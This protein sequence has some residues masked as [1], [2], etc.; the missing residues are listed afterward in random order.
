MEVGMAM[1]VLQMKNS[2]IMCIFQGYQ[3]SQDSKAG[4]NISNPGLLLCL[5]FYFF[6]EV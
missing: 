4:W 1:P 3:Q 2:K 5:H 6:I